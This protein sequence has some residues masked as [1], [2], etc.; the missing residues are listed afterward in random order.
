MRTA[1]IIEQE[2]AMWLARQDGG[3]WSAGDD[4]A[5]ARW[6]GQCIEHEVSFYRLESAWRAADRL[7]A[8][9]APAH[10]TARP[11]RLRIWWPMAVA[12]SLLLLCVPA[13][14]I[15]RSTQVTAPERFATAHGGHSAVP[16]ADGSRVE[17]NTDTVI[18]AEIANDRRRVWLERGEAFFDVAHDPARPF[19]VLAGSHRVIVVG[20]KFSVRRDGADMRVSVL[21]GGVRVEPVQPAV[22]GAAPL[23]LLGPGDQAMASGTNALILPNSQD[24]VTAALGWRTGTLL[25]DRT[26]LA[27]AAAE[28]NRYNRRQ[29]RIGSG[30]LDRMTISGR[31]DADNVDAFARLLGKAYGLRIRETADTLE[32]SE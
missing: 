26:A 22:A 16:L 29:L 7:T 9:R 11:R 2:A 1:A 28:F 10:A 5:F 27:D 6:L 23:R 19:E 8:L 15:H 25:F 31:F 3:D 17:L 18:R 30:A 20:T 24:R 12:A 4:D 13:L 21:E 14:L 32:I